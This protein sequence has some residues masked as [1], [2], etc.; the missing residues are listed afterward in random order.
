MPL[1][2]SRAYERCALCLVQ[3][4]KLVVPNGVLLDLRRVV[5]N[6][7]E[8]RLEREDLVIEGEASESRFLRRLL[9]LSL[10]LL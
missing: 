10:T 1:F 4:S 2:L 6:A 5:V 8:F 9:S 3:Y 7:A